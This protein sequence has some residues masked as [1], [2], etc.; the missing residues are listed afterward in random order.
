VKETSDPRKAARERPIDSIRVGERHRKELGD[1]EALAASIADVG[2]L[3]PVVV[4]ADGERVAGERRLEAC[5]LLGWKE[6]PVTVVDLDAVVRGEFA[7]NAVRKDFTLSEAVAIKRALEP[8]ER[9]AARER[10]GSP[11]KFSEL[12]KGN[13]LD[14]VAA[15]VGKHRTTIAKAEAIVD[16]AEAEPEKFGKLLDDMDRCGRANGPFRRLR[17]MQQAA[18]IRAE[19]PPL[20]GRGPYRCAVIDLPWPY[21]HDDEDPSDRAIRPYTTMSISEIHAF[22]VTS[23]M[24][25]DSVCGCG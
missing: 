5:K 19:P 2:L 12:A 22:P 7:E 8:L 23:I 21:E 18:L 6:V 4:N 15:V 14:K 9:A 25:A 24:H 3:H 1:V 20:P 17:N 13:A 10:M 11:E 16:A